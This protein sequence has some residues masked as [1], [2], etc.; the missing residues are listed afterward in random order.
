MT[1]PVTKLE[2]GDA[3]NRTTSAISSGVPTRPSGAGALVTCSTSSGTIASRVSVRT[4]PAQT[5]LTR[6]P[7]GPHSTA[8]DRV[9]DSSAA[10]VPLYAAATGMPIRAPIDEVLT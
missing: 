6:T 3:R 1:A 10:L 4:A 7:D 2:R 8:H 5:A 9:I